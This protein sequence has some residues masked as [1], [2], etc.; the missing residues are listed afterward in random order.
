MEDA[1][2]E[3]VRTGGRL[4]DIGKI[5][6]RE[7]ILNNVGRDGAWE[8]LVGKNYATAMATIRKQANRTTPAT[9]PR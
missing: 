2:V 1:Q 4:H 8:D 9:M 7:E 6:I 3:A 5:G